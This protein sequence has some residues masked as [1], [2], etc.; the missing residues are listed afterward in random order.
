MALGMMGG[1]VQHFHYNVMKEIPA[2][3]KNVVHLY[4][5]EV[6][7]VRLWTA[8]TILVG[9]INVS[10]NYDINK[11]PAYTHRNICSHKNVNDTLCI[12]F[13]FCVFQERL[14]LS[15]LPRHVAMEMKADINA[16]KEDMMFHKIYIQK[17]DNVRSAGACVL[18]TSRRV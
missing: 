4:I 5:F 17:H 1:K 8:L 13:L 14:L 2:S 18:N 3:A 11:E 9:L 12:L 10:L 7:H 15:V 6:Q 16:K